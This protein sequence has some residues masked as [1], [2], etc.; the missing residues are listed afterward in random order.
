MKRTFEV[1]M[2]HYRQQL[3]LYFMKLSADTVQ[4]ELDELI[5]QFSYEVLPK[6]ELLLEAGQ[7]SDT[8]YFICKG[9]VR[10]YYVKEEKEITNWFIQENMM[11]AATYSILT[12]Q[13]NYSSYETLEETHVL[14]IK[15]AVLESFYTRYHSLEHMG[16]KL[17]QAY[18]G[19]FMKKTFDVLFL[20]AEERYHLFVKDHADLLNRVP[21]R[22]VAS[23]LGITQETLSRLRSK[24]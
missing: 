13:P 1:N 18:Y 22:Y 6:K 11:F 4:S 14:K 20:S 24:H 10:I 17:I 9:L 5:Q 8:V 2:D 12:G 15:Y 7:S 19:A 21:L 16:R 23:Y 3:K